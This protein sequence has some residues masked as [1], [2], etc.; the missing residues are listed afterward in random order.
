MVLSSLLVKIVV[1]RV[2]HRILNIE[3]FTLQ[4]LVHV[5]NM[6]MVALLR[7]SFV[8]VLDLLIKLTLLV[9]G[10]SS[11]HKLFSEALWLDLEPTFM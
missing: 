4:V 3:Q 11:W 6:V 9:G 8:T 7:M 1:V 10:T 2:A 5:I